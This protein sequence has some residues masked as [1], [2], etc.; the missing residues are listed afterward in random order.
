MSQITTIFLN[1][2]IDDSIEIIIDKGCALLSDL[3]T[4]TPSGTEATTIFADDTKNPACQ[5]LD[6]PEFNSPQTSRSVEETPCMEGIPAAQW[7]TPKN[8]FKPNLKSTASNNILTKNRFS[9]LSANCSESS[10]ADGTN[11]FSENPVKPTQL[12]KERPRPLIKAAIKNK[13]TKP[14][15]G[16][17]SDSILKFATN[18]KIKNYSVEKKFNTFIRPNIGAKIEHLQHHVVP[19]FEKNPDIIIISAGHNNLADD[20]LDS[21][22]VKMEKLVKFLQ[23]KDIIVVISMLT[24]RSDEHKKKAFEYNKLLLNLCARYL[25]SYIDNSNILFSDLDRFGLHLSRSGTDTVCKNISQFL[26]Y[27]VRHVYPSGY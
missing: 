17:I 9:A 1:K 12:F 19:S 4:T 25:V 8:T 24:P 5:D 6:T 2:N 13:K 7:L 23:D 27:F 11:I 21:M 14:L 26:D 16:V 22:I 15:V 3:A 20:S 10:D 18:K